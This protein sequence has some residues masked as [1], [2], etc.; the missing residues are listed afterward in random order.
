MSTVTQKFNAGLDSQWG[1]YGAQA[2]L[3][4]KAHTNAKN[5]EKRFPAFLEA[6]NG[7]E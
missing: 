7:S 1:N 5:L 3:L 2:Y 6:R 4:L